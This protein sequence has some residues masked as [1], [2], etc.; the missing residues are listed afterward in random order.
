MARS[1]AR[2]RSRAYD[3][4]Y[5]TEKRCGNLGRYVSF[6]EIHVFYNMYVLNGFLTTDGSCTTKYF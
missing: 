3:F 1:W 4:H 5:S 6:N 2:L